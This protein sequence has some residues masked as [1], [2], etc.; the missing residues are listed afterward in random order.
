MTSYA[1]P[2]TSLTGWCWIGSPGG[3]QGDEVKCDVGVG[4]L[5]RRKGA[6]REEKRIQKDLQY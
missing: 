2:Q 4:I 1:G 6:G 3:R 5:G